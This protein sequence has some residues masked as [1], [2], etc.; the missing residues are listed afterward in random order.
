MQDCQ[1]DELNK[2]QFLKNV[3]PNLSQN[4]EQHNIQHNIHNN[5]IQHIENQHQNITNNIT[6]KMDNLNIFDQDFDLTHI[7]DLNK[8]NI[9]LSKYIYS[10]FYENILKNRS[11]NNIVI[12]E[13]TQSAFVYNKYDD[14]D[15]YKQCNLDIIIEDVMKKLNKQLKVILHH[16]EPE[17]DNGNKKLKEVFK[18]ANQDINDKFNDFKKSSNVKNIVNNCFTKILT[19]NKIVALEFVKDKFSSNENIQ[20]KNNDIGY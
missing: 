15:D 6:I 17:F 20:N 8:L 5:N 4:N 2:K 18:D 1:I 12:D 16:L 10:S 14:K 13:K 9:I 3:S 11:N 7:N 19:D